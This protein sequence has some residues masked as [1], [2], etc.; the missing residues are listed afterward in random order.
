V[1]GIQPGENVAVK[2]FEKLQDIVNVAVQNRPN[3]PNE[4]QSP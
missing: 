1:Q 3:G 4:R 2:G